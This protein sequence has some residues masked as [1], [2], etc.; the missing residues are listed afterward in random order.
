MMRIAGAIAE[1]VIQRRTPMR[2]LLVEDEPDLRS[3]LTRALR[4]EGYAVDA[5][6][7]GDDGLFN[8][9]NTDYD[10]IV[11]DVM[12]PTMDGWRF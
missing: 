3:A 1:F 4:D 10:A 5:A 11:L 9:Q 12:L 2:I 7:N 6:E 8:A